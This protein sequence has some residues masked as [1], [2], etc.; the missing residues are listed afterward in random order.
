MY[1]KATRLQHQFNFATE[2]LDLTLTTDY[3][4]NIDLYAVRLTVWIGTISTVEHVNW[5]DN[6]EVTYCLVTRQID[7]TAR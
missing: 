1:L 5:D 2:N 3:R 7:S 6:H 4:Y